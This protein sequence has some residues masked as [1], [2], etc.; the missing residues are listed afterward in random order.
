MF[1]MGGTGSKQEDRFN[2]AAIEQK[3]GV[4]FTY[5]PYKGGGEVA[6][7]LVEKPVDS[8]V[9]NPIEAVRQW[10]DGKLR[11]PCVFDSK[12]MNYTDTIAAGKSWHDIPTSTDAGLDGQSPRLR[13]MR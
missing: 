3:T 9:N 11:P 2:T 10:R 8:A 6:D 12:A 13:R 1:K 5:V 4:K 7:H